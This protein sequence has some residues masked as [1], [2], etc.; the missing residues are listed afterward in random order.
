MFGI[1]GWPTADTNNTETGRAYQLT[2][3]THARC[4]VQL[5]PCLARLDVHAVERHNTQRT[6]LPRE[7]ALQVR[8]I[9]S[10]RTTAIARSTRAR[11]R[12]RQLR[13]CLAATSWLQPILQCISVCCPRTRSSTRPGLRP[14]QQHYAHL[15]MFAAHVHF[16][17]RDRT[18]TVITTEIFF[19]AHADATHKPSQQVISSSSHAIHSRLGSVEHGS[20]PRQTVH[21]HCKLVRIHL[22][23]G[24]L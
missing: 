15:G 24:P 22:L 16:A 20:W 4:A 21:R 1:D 6:R 10:S 23:H 19:G 14:L 13:V 17:H 12:N 9:G 2:L 11:S 3:F 18:V 7:F 5:D 8:E